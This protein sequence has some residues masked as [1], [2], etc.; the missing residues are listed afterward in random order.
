MHKTSEDGRLKQLFESRCRGAAN[1]NELEFQLA[2]S[3]LRAFDLY[4][5][6]ASDAVRLE[7]VEDVDARGTG[8]SKS[9][10]L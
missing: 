1:I 10:S 9:Q 5:K 8:G 3:I 6:G 4:E 2:Y 7:A